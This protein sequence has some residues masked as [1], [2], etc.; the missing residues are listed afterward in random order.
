MSEIIATVFSVLY[1]LIIASTVLLILTDDQDSGRKLAWI[2]VIVLLP[3]IGLVLHIVFGFNPRRFGDERYREE[4]KAKKIFESYF[5]GAVIERIFGKCAT[6]KIRQ[7]YRELVT[8]LSNSNGTTV[9][10]GNNIEIITSGERKLEALLEDL[11][12]ARHH[13]HMEYFYFRKDKGSKM[14]REVLMRKAREGVQVRFIHENI[15][16]IDIS[17]IYYNQMKKAGV[18]V[19]RFTR[20]DLFSIFKFTTKLNYRDHRKLVVIDG[21]IGYTGGMN[22]GDDYFFRWRD[23]HMRIT[24]N[25]VLSLQYSFFNS[26]IGSGG[27]I[28]DISDYKSYFPETEKVPGAD[29]LVQI[30]PDEPDDRWPIIQMGAVWTVQHTREYI[31][32]QTPYFVPPEPLLQSLK[33]AALKG[34]DVRIMMPEKADSIY[35]GP[36]NR[37]YYTECLKSGIRIFERTG[38]FMHSK[39]MVSDDYLSVIGSANM[40]YRSLEINYEINAY[41]FGEATAGLNKEIF[42]KDLDECEEIT[43]S[44]WIRRPWYDKLI[45]SVVR[46]FAPLL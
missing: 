41:I 18:K 22:I 31:Y 36:A 27:G 17:P 29:K 7:P 44:E 1:V 16:N 28:S 24:G 32:I 9:T 43:L 30:V 46:L 45:Q 6:E 37:S 34:A 3:V 19:V 4:A 20:P 5:S 26:Y 14:I 25:A 10:D 15:A 40:D 8:L 13:I 39:T 11:E 23:T 21:K 12:N 38:R 33:A 2:L 42:L 35:M